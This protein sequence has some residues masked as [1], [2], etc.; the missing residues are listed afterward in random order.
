MT[1]LDSDEAQNI[2]VNDSITLRLSNAM[3]IDADA[4]YIMQQETGEVMI[5]FKTNKA[6]EEL[7]SYRKISVDVVWW[8]KSGLK[9]PNSAIIEEGGDNYVI[10]NRT[11]YKD[12]I[13]VDVT[14]Q[15][16]NYSI[17]KNYS[18]KELLEKGLDKDE[19]Y[20]MKTIGLH[21]EVVLYAK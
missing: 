16:K 1:F 17:I 6:V 9:V 13:M 7:I 8:S 15:N 14:A 3:E 20:S 4:I 2:G 5:I 12:K 18:G 19:A 10:R 21:D 11:G